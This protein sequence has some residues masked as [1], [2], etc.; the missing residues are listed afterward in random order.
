MRMDWDMMRGRKILLI[1]DDEA[2]R[3]TL[4]EQLQL[5]EGFVTSEASTAK[6][7]LVAA[8][9]GG[10]DLLLLDV[11]L[12]DM[13]GR[14]M[15]RLLRKQNVKAPVILLTAQSTDADTILGLDAGASDYITKPFKLP[16]LL[17]RIRSQLRQHEQSDEAMFPIGPYTFHPAGNLLIDAERNK[18]VHLTSKET[19]ILKYLYR[20][21]GRVV[22]REI[23][24]QELW[25]YRAAVHTHTVETHVYR[26]RQ[27][28]EPDASESSIVITEPG[29]YRLPR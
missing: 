1:D 17:A 8:T 22:T 26:L 19:S 4:A 14:N 3:T 29:G 27:K 18:K 28:L 12:P 24:L 23:L 11:A 5:H 9:G 7:G 15:C 13:D 25:G 2:F 20:A 21:N 10:H 16:V 6:D